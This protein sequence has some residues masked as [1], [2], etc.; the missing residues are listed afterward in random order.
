MACLSRP[1][2]R[3]AT[4]SIVCFAACLPA[5]LIAAPPTPDELLGFS[6][7]LPDD[8]DG[9]L[10]LLQFGEL[11][12]TIGD[13]QVWREVSQTPEV[14]AAIAGAT[15]ALADKNIPP[16]ARL[17]LDLLAAAGEAEVTIAAKPDVSKNLQTLARLGVLSI[18]V[19]APSPFEL[20]S[21]EGA[22][23]ELKR[24]EMR[25]QWTAAAV[26]LRV[27][28]L[29]VAVRI[30]DRA[31][32]EP[33]VRGMLAMG[34]AALIEEIKKELPSEPAAIVARAFEPKTYGQVTLERF[35]LR[36]GDVVPAE[37]LA[38]PLAKTPLEDDQRA[39][40]AQALSNLTIDVHV[41]FVG[42]YLTLV[43]SA[44]DSFVRDIVERFEGRTAGSLAA[45]AEFAPI[46]AE[47][48]PATIG[49]LY[50]DAAQ[51]LQ[52]LRDE[53]LP[54]IATVTSAEFLSQLGAPSK[55][56][57][58]AARVRTDL[59][60]LVASSPV[61]QHSVMTM[62]RGVRQFLRLEHGGEPVT[63][64]T[65]PLV[66]PGW[67]PA[68]AVGFIAWRDISLDALWEQ[69]RFAVAQSQT[70]LDE[71]RFRFGDD[72]FVRNQISEG[73]KELAAVLKPIDGKLSSSLKGE[74]TFMLGSVV[75]LKVQGPRG[76][77]LEGIPTPTVA[78]VIKSPNARAAIDGL[79][80][81]FDAVA[82]LMHTENP[83]NP[84]PF[85]AKLAPKTVDA[86]ETWT[87]SFE[88]ATVTGFEPHL[89]QVGDALVVSTSFE[90]TKQIRAAAA[91]KSSAIGSTA[92]YLDV[93]PHLPLTADQLTY[94]D[95]AA[96]HRNLRSMVDGG[97]AFVE[98]SDLSLN[99]RDPE[100]LANAKR[101][102]ELV[103]RAVST[104]RGAWSARVID[105]RVETLREWIRFEDVAPKPQ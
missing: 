52:L 53:L 47:L 76:P 9:Y 72:E 15:Q 60:G 73:R 4:A 18:G 1:I 77:V 43:V 7:Y 64:R 31:K 40:L 8:V 38:E 78:V 20:D 85:P 59:E 81:L 50:A 90:F 100:M 48:T 80:Q 37:A 16:E 68:S 101:I 3:L 28:S 25:T 49:I 63:P 57:P 92:A 65:K 87:L 67:V 35:H 42:D 56:A 95:G 93:E 2:R 22:A 84:K 70:E 23:L 54:L 104:F 14:A 69:I 79:V 44:D 74:T 34:R 94:L 97:F 51:S 71:L 105:G 61:K 5:T 39:A 62:D 66:T 45:S 86:A 82:D 19:F 41:G 13:S 99:N 89:T 46:R 21:P 24:R 96:L 98:R 26:S 58:L 27:P 55:I 29:A 30:K 75:P 33:F 36:L 11:A 103:I 102:S 32:F 83:F 17:A 88:E 6:R 12:R 91:E 10:S